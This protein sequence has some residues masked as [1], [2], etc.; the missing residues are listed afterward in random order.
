MRQILTACVL[1]IGLVPHLALAQAGPPPVA[2]AAQKTGDGTRQGVGF[3]AGLVSGVGFAYRRHFANKFG[4]QIGGS[5]WAGRDESFLNLGGEVIRTLS[6]S[7]RSRLYLVA[8][9]SIWRYRQPD[10]GDTR[11]VPVAQGTP[12]CPPTQQR[13]TGS[14]NLGAGI[15]LEFAGSHVGLSL[16]VPI[17]LM[18]DLEDAH[19][20]IYPIPGVSL[21][22]YF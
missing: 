18:L 6:R 13:T 21:V 14:A 17:S 19:L 16:E 11:C 8:G 10:Y 22:Y 20:S 12:A 4:L 1:L 9:T 2:D 7:D 15:G 3:T 5:G